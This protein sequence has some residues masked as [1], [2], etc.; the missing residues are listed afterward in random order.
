ML[1]RRTLTQCS[2]SRVLGRQRGD[3]N[4]RE[5]QVRV[6]ESEDTTSVMSTGGNRALSTESPV[7]AEGIIIRDLERFG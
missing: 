4:R 1:E 5:S 3:R 7:C 6:D 2:L